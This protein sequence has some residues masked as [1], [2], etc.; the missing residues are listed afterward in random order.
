ML[1]PCLDETKFSMVP[2]LSF[3]ITLFG[4][5]GRGEMRKERG[6]ERREGREREEARGGGRKRVHSGV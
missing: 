6:E 5:K 4:R 1:L 3:K 2:F